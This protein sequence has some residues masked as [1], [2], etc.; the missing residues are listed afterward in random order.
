MKAWLLLALASASF[1]DSLSL[2]QALSLA[3][4][5][6]P[7]LELSRADLDAARSRRSLTA[8]ALLPS[9][10]ITTD[11]SR[12]GP[13]AGGGARSNAAK[14]M[15]GDAQLKTTLAAEWTVFDGFR[16]WGGLGAARAREGAAEAEEA[17]TI[18]DVDD[19]V[20]QRWTALW[21]ASRRV[22]AALSGLA[23]SRERRDVARR[24]AELGSEA[25]LESRQ[26]V[27]DASRDSLSWIRADAARSNAS[28]ALDLALGRNP[29][30]TSCASDPGAPDTVDPLS[31]ATPAESPRLRAARLSEEAADVDVSSSHGTF[32]PSL[33]VYADYIHLGVLQDAPPPGNA[34]DQAM[35][36]G[37][38]ATW[39]LFEGG[40]DLARVRVA[41]SDR[42]KARSARLAL[43][44]S[45]KAELDEARLR[46]T[47]ARM[48]WDL[49]R[50]NDIQAGLVLDAARMRYDSGDMSGLDLRRYQDSRLQARLDLDAAHAELLL[51]AAALR[52]AA[53][54][55]VRP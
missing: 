28:R 10:G 25:G 31:V 36:Y 41:Q 22:E 2:D 9:L 35:V 39:S 54:L 45:E 53:G 21:L 16:S 26:A 48:A 46:W 5:G 55:S 13:N 49:E 27:L 7:S 15:S 1:A 37:A 43:E 29:S 14:T 33:S 42:A 17:A 4:T 38:T 12:L 18:A 44:R 52:E 8:G 50:S 51:A 3:R 11:Y 47:T 23:V 40:S 24:R 19:L 30:G 34:W 6:N 32:W 20:V